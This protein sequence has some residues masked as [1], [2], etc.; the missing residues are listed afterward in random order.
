MYT[1]AYHKD[2]TADVTRLTNVSKKVHTMRINM[3]FEEHRAWQ[4]GAVI[5]RALPRATPEQREFLLSGTTPEEWAI[6]FPPEKE[7]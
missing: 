5:Q 1:V 7:D 2:G 4:S 6:L 3:T